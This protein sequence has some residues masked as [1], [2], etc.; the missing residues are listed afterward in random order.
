MRRT[1]AFL[2]SLLVALNFAWI[3]PVS[4]KTDYSRIRV[5]LAS[6]GAP[7]TGLTHTKL[8]ATKKL[9]K[10]A[11]IRRIKLHRLER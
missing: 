1:L 7:D 5:A 2:I 4:A 8:S 10:I 9:T 11:K 3:C 6:M